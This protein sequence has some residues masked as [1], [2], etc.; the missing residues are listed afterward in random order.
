MDRASV[1]TTYLLVDGENIDATLGSNIF[2]GRR[3]SPQE[4]PRWERVRDFA[5]ETWDR[6]VKALFFLNAS[7]GQLPLPFIQA[8]LALDY[9]PIPLSGGAGEKVVDIGIQRT[10]DALV[11]RPGDV[12]LASHDGDFFDQIE[13]L[14]DGNRRVGL[15]GFREFVNS[16]FTELT[17]QGLEIYDLEDD[18]RCFNARL[19]RVRIINIDRFDPLPYL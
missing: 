10:L 17:A 2:G 7:S 19:P 15:L 4:R 14:L 3:P 12:L 5:S 1:Q 16:R 8:L 18:V 9:Q 6:Q 11:D 13:R